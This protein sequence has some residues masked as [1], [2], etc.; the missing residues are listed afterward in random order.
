MLKTERSA[1][2]NHVN[3][4]PS[5][6][7]LSRKWK[8]EYEE[9]HKQNI[10]IYYFF[11]NS[12]Q[13][14]TQD[15]CYSYP[16][17]TNICSV[18]ILEV[19]YQFLPNKSIKKINRLITCS[20]AYSLMTQ[21]KAAFFLWSHIPQQSNHVSLKLAGSLTIASWNSRIQK[22]F[23]LFTTRP[24]WKPYS[25][26]SNLQWEKTGM[27]IRKAQRNP[28]HTKTDRMGKNKAT[29]KQLQNF[30]SANK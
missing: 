10:I 24:Q 28:K 4:L 13:W 1:A 21:T 23:S 6:A 25:S 20:F 3:S 11:D 27:N 18:R 15:A 2:E 12:Q 29:Y 16:N 8:K 7:T 14:P 9:H 17:H 5:S 19:K 30:S 26:L 22:Y